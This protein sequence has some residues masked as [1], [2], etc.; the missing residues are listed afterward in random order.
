MKSVK[1]LSEYDQ[2]VVKRQVLTILRSP[3]GRDLGRWYLTEK[4]KTDGNLA[5]IIREVQDIEAECILDLYASPAPV[6]S[7]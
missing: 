4:G 2:N 5:Q 7:R 6:Q 1:I 3:Q